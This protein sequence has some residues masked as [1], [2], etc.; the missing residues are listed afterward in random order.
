[1]LPNKSSA[2]ASRSEFTTSGCP[3]SLL[4]IPGIQ[5]ESF[6]NPELFKTFKWSDLRGRQC[7]LLLLLLDI[8]L[9]KSINDEKT[10]RYYL[11]DSEELG[12]PFW[13]SG[14]SL[15]SCPE[16]HLKNF[17]GLLFAFEFISVTGKFL[18]ETKVSKTSEAMSQSCFP[19]ELKALEFEIY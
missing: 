2:L 6:K 1:M 5:L 15:P 4:E 17:F 19:T 3:F 12:M 8:V 10:T 11:E 13:L 18:V 14:S 7:L 9:V 16:V